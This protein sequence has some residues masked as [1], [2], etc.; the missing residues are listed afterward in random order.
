MYKRKGV[1]GKREGDMR[2]IGRRNETGRSKGGR[3][4]CLEGGRGTLMMRN[5]VKYRTRRRP[6]YHI[7]SGGRETCAFWTYKEF[8]LQYYVETT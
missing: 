8:S 6:P 5:D 2:W 4:R 3:W 7:H 1:D